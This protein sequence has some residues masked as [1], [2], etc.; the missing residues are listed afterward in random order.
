MKT[1]QLDKRDCSLYVLQRNIQRLL[2]DDIDINE[3]KNLTIY[4]KNGISLNNLLSIAKKYGLKFDAF[5]ANIDQLCNLEKSGF[6]IAAIIR[7]Q[8]FLHMVEITKIN[9]HYVYYFDPAV[10]KVIK[11]T[12][13]EFTDKFAKVLIHFTKSKTIKNTIKSEQINNFNTFNVKNL[14]LLLVY[15]IEFFISFSFPFVN[16]IFINYL[17]NFKLEKHLYIISIFILW[18]I[19]INLFANLISNKIANKII[20]INVFNKTKEV[21]GL[22]GSNNSKIIQQLSTSEIKNRVFAISLINKFTFGFYPIIISNIVSIIL[23]FIL[24][25]NINFNLIIILIIY[26]FVNLLLNFINKYFYDKNYFNLVNEQLVVETNFENYINHLKTPYEQLL[27]Q[28]LFVKYYQSYL[29]LTNKSVNFN[30]KLNTIQIIQQTWET[31]IPFIIL[32][33]SAFEIWKGN[34]TI[35]SMIFFL[36]SASLFTRPI[37]SFFNLFIEY[38]EYKKAIIMLKVFNLEI[39]NNQFNNSNIQTIKKFTISYI[40]YSPTSDV[41]NKI[42]GIS[43][44]IIDKN[45]ILFGSNGCGKTTLCKIL[46]GNLKIDYGD[47]LINDQKVDLFKDDELKNKI[48]Y[49]GN[50]DLN[51]NISIVEYLNLQTTDNINQVWNY[52]GVDKIINRLKINLNANLNSLSKG[53]L[54]LVKLLKLLLIPYDVIILDEAFENLDNVCFEH[55]K[56]IIKKYFA[57]KLIIEISHNNK[58]VYPESE[59]INVEQINQRL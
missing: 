4:A 25:Y 11:E 20:Q 27:S 3:L 50:N 15:L 34:L 53:Q 46:N 1:T 48:Y 19:L 52:F 36:T 35:V 40:S 56:K 7:N 5:N 18:S 51:L 9:K 41:N 49:I 54:Q 39:D 2:D 21:V 13:V 38:Q 22:L 43:R 58:F 37:K 44:L 30:N 14:Y 16:K 26:T 6:P 17:I 55:I 28:N 12:I 59:K 57:N 24:F 33:A 32:I 42:L 45:V 29:T 23:S 47:I 31:M 8:N 10:N